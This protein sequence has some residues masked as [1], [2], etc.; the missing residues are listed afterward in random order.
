[1]LE[2]RRRDNSKQWTEK[3][4]KSLFYR[5]TNGERYFF[6]VSPPT[7]VRQPRDLGG[8]RKERRTATVCLFAGLCRCLSA[9]LSIY[10][11][12]C[13]P[14][15]LCAYVFTRLLSAGVLVS[16]LSIRLAEQF[17]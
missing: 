17:E 15:C 16:C 1:M 12:A 8:R 10:L 13:L 2:E 14:V 5:Q 7:H 4:M 3:D 11:C 9:W 6:L